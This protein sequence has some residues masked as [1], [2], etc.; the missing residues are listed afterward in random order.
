MTTGPDTLTSWDSY[1]SSADA[2]LRSVGCQ[3]WERQGSRIAKWKLP[4]GLILEEND[5]LAELKE[6]IEI[7]AK[8]KKKKKVKEAKG[9][10]TC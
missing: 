1:P 7:S 10:E 4:D 3:I 5:A 9:E 6:A 2:M 8:A